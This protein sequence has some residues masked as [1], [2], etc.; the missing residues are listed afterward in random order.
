[1]GMLLELIERLV[2]EHGSASVLRDHLELIKSKAAAIE[3]EN[4]DLRAQVQQLQL[5]LAEK[6]KALRGMQQQLKIFHDDN[7]NGYIERK[8]P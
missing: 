2:T 1:M 6:E 4:S 3:D 8:L 7:P 5:D